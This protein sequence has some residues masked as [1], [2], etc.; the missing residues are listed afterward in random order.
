MSQAV[1][2][3]EQSNSFMSKLTSGTLRII[4]SLVIPLL[5]FAVLAWSVTYMT[6]SDAPKAIRAVVALLVGVGGIWVLYIA[7]DNLVSLL[8]VHLREGV[9]PFVFVG[10]ALV[11]IT[12]Y[13]LYPLVDTLIRS[14]KDAR[15]VNFVGLENYKFIF[16]DP[17][18]LIVLRNNLLWLVFVTS[19]AVGLGLVIAVMV[20]R[21]RWESAVKSIIFLPMAISAVGAS[22]IWKFIYTFRPAGRPQIGLLNAIWVALGGDPQGWLILQP[23]NNFF[24]IIIYIWILVGFAMVVI[25]AAVK[26][27]PNEQLEA[28]RIDG[29]SEIQIFFKVIIPNIRPTLLTITT[30][31]LI[32]V[33]KVFDIVF[34]MTS[35]QFGTQV[36]ANSMFNQ[37]FTF[38]QFGRASALAVILLIG[39]IPVI[40][41]NVRSFREAR[42]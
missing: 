10:P 35:G 26:G 5:T 8:P 31:I 13:L 20:D 39:V 1:E 29:A 3:K 24:L 15:S 38:R 17:N 22:V 28:A 12:V 4:V 37:M 25:S 40:F 21:I 18:M 2:K 41:Y 32:M 30:T 42:S 14:F 9:R 7:F 23:W 19:F 11:I 6:N 27:V 36:I 34:V 16:T 33:L